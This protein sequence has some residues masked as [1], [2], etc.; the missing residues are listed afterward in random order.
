MIGMI[1]TGITFTILLVAVIIIGT[2]IIIGIWGDFD[3]DAKFFI[4]L[5]AT[6]LITFPFFLGQEFQKL[7]SYNSKKYK[8]ELDKIEISKGDTIEYYKVIELKK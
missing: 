3:G 1:I 5:M 7:S 8:W 4:S 6:I 2:V